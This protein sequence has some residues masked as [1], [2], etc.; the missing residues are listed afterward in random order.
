MAEP[1]GLRERKKA[2][3]KAAL[4]EAA[5]R[6]AVEKGGI[7]AVTADE[8]AARAGVSTR[9]FH[10]YFPSKEAAL[11][12]DFHQTTAV[13]VADLRERARHQPIWDALRD[14]AIGMNLDRLDIDLMRCREELVHTSPALIKEQSGQFLELFAEAIDIVAEAT[15]CGPDDLYP[16]LLLGGALVTIKTCT[17][18]WLADPEGRTL[19]EVIT[20]G[21]AVFERGVTRPPA[22]GA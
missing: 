21:F 11:L 12:Y 15:G 10:N 1:T 7:E 19:A 9:T 4:G 8:I 17:E 18:H 5:L 16:R 6:L 2:A 22:P 13:L 3:T 14:G 20:E